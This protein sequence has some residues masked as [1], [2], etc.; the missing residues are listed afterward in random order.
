LDVQLDTM[1][2][3]PLDIVKHVPLSVLLV[4]VPL[5]QI[6][7]HVL[8]QI[9]FKTKPFVYQDVYWANIWTTEPAWAVQLAVSFVQT[10]SLVPVA[11]TQHS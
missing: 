3:L 9:F 11:Q 1:V 4:M 2:L 10:P 5:M 6:V 8:L 7:L